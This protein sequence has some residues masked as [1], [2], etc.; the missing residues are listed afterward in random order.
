MCFRVALKRVVEGKLD[1]GEVE[2]S[3]WVGV[4]FTQSSLQMRG[5]KNLVDV[6][7]VFDQ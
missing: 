1:A 4:H 3:G 5:R 6:A 7:C 2:P